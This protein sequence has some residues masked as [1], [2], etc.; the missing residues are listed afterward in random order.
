MGV[1]LVELLRR[2]P[3]LRDDLSTG[4]LDRVALEEFRLDSKKRVT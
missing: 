2:N 1:E 3:Q 4:L